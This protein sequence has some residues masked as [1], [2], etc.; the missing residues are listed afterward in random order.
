MNQVD[1][2]NKWLSI[3]LQQKEIEHNLEKKLKE[4]SELTLNEFYVLYFLSQE[5][6]RSM[7]IF[8]L[9]EKVHLT[10]SAMSRLISRMEKKE[11]SGIIRGNCPKDKRGVC[12]K[13]TPEG[14][15]ELAKHIHHVKSVLAECQEFLKQNTI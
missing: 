11:H 14:E 1:C 8:D 5:P 13:L 9:Q 15:Q 3:S 2:I 4:V 7:R 10:Q 6:Q 12:I